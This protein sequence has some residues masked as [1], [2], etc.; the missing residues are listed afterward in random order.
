MN[1]LN[2][3]GL[4]RDS[5]YVHGGRWSKTLKNCWIV[6]AAIDSTL[7]RSPAAADQLIR[8]L[9]VDVTC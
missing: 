4:G 3:A 1:D 7:Q 8:L 6:L 2:E 9:E 5:G